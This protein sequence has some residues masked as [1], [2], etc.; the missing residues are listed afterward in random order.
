MKNRQSRFFAI[1]LPILFFSFLIAQIPDLV[2]QEDIDADYISYL[3]TQ[4]SAWLTQVAI[5]SDDAATIKAH[6]GLALLAVAWSTVDGDTAFTDLDSLG[7]I[8]SANID[9]VVSR[10]LDELFP[11]LDPFE[12]D[13]ILL[14]LTDFFDS[15]NYELFRDFIN[16]KSEALDSDF[17]NTGEVMDDL[18]KDIRDNFSPENFGSHIDSIFSSTADFEF[19]L[20]ILASDI[21]DSVMF[22]N[23]AFFSHL[24]DL[25]AIGD[26]AGQNFDR[27]GTWMDS[28]MAITGGDVMPGI[29]YF[30][31]GLSD[32]D[33]FIDTL[34]V[35]LTNQPFAPFAIDTSP[36]DSLQQ[37]V[38][39]VDTL[40]AGK[41]YA[42]GPEDENK[43]IR[44]LAIIQNMPGDGLYDT[45][46]GFY[47]SGESSAYSFGGIFPGGLDSQTLELMSADLVVN[48]WDDDSAFDLRLK[49]LKAAWQLKLWVTPDDPDAHLGI[50]MV[51]FYEMMNNNVENLNDIFRLLDMGRIDSLTYYHNWESLNLMDDLDEIDAHLTYFTEAGEPVH[52]VALVKS[53]PDAYGPYVIGATS[54][55]EIINIFEF[56]VDAA[57]AELNLIQFGLETIQAVFT[58]LYE[59]LDDMFILNLDPTVLDFSTVDS[60]SDLVMLL[61]LS[62]PDFLTLTPYG[63]QRFIEM[64]DE[65]EDGFYN[66]NQFYNLMVDLSIAMTPYED[67][68]AMNGSAFTDEME[69][70]EQIS[71]DIWQDFAYS[72]STVTIAEERVNLSAWF[73]NPPVSFLDMWQNYVFGIDSTLGGL[74][75]DRFSLGTT[76]YDKIGIPASFMVYDAYPNPFNPVTIIYFDLPKNGLVDVTIYNIRGEKVTTLVHDVRKAG[77]ISLPWNAIGNASGVY[78]YRVTYGD[79]TVTKKVLLLK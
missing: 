4:E 47:R 39:E 17:N 63:T 61:E 60:D 15:G 41:Q 76:P 26:S 72:D 52:F 65:L 23:R 6:L 14:S 70:M 27:F 67:D 22:I 33:Q 34:R 64:G 12:I 9:S 43:T 68:F 16:T 54:E 73:D 69:A 38:A 71:F 18:F 24:E 53:G 31:E 25:G 59:E 36:L 45:Y 46:T 78:L 50:A 8:I 79:Q 19:S 51:M 29:A 7:N 10:S 77:T 1:I 44:P 48:N 28:V 57:Q 11:I 20:Q 13:S 32:V 5:G 66:I 74:F 37:A 21:P 75:P 55:F 62:N 35:V 40:L 56:M 2:L 3:S 30:R 42:F 58:S 49:A